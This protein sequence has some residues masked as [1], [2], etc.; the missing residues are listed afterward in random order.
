[1]CR[2]TRES[3]GPHSLTALAQHDQ[4]RLYS[5]DVSNIFMRLSGSYEHTCR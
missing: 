4:D 3:L 5:L 2:D 1:M